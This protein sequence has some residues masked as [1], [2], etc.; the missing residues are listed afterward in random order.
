LVKYSTRYRLSKKAIKELREEVVKV[1]GSPPLEWN[2]V[3]EAKAGDITVYIDSGLP[4]LARV[5]G[6]LMPTLLCLLK[7]GHTWLP[8][9]IVDRGA[10]QAMGRGADLM[11]PGVRGVKGDFKEGALV[12]IVDEQSG[13]PVAVGRALVDSARLRQMI[14]AKERG[15]VVENLHYPGDE[16]WDLIS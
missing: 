13:V 11:A 2:D 8:S 15:K 9:V 4:C 14:S 6:L 16:L 12:A 5:K 7:R 3:E 1:L 10:T